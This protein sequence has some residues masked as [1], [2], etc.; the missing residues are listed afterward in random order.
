MAKVS[1]SIVS[2]FDAPPATGTSKSQVIWFVQQLDFFV[3]SETGV[4]IVVPALLV[5]WYLFAS[6][7]ITLPPHFAVSA[8]QHVEASLEP[9]VSVAQKKF[10]GVPLSFCPAA[11]KE[12]CPVHAC[13]AVQQ[14]DFFVASVTGVAISVPALLVSWYLFASHVIT[15]PPHFVVSGSQ[16]VEASA[17][18][19]LLVVQ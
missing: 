7:V 12:P 2:D 13:L 3:V 4:V 10:S 17:V 14:L 5:S 11:H 15:L 8:S 19:Q 16:H 1:A 18:V 6:H 9:Q